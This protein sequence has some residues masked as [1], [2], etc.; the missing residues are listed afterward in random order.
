MFKCGYG[1]DA[2]NLGGIE[3]A[4]PDV[5]FYLSHKQPSDSPEKTDPPQPAGFPAFSGILKITDGSIRTIK[6]DRSEQI[7]V[8]DLDLFLDISDIEK[9][10][11][12]RVFLTSGDTVGRSYLAGQLS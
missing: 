4:K 12:Y 1:A 9:P 8:K 7:V 11:A 3:I 10:I 2:G 6:P 5:V